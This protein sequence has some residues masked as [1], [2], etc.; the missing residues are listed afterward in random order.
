MEINFF[1]CPTNYLKKTSYKVDKYYRVLNW[2]LIH[3][4]VKLRKKTLFEINKCQVDHVNTQD[5]TRME[6]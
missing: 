6:D 3:F 5:T 4:K 2:L 1:V